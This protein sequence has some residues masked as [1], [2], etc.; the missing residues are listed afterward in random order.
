MAIAGVS[1]N[2]LSSD[3]NHQMGPRLSSAPNLQKLPQEHQDR[4]SS[5]DLAE[6]AGPEPV[7]YRVAGAPAA[8][9]I[10]APHG[11]RGALCHSNSDSSR[12]RPVTLPHPTA[13]KHSHHVTLPH[14]MAEKHSRPVNRRNHA[15]N[16]NWSRFEDQTDADHHHYAAHP[17]PRVTLPRQKAGSCCC[18]GYPNPTNELNLP[19]ERASTTNSQTTCCH[20]FQSVR[21]DLMV[22]RMA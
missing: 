11:C 22:F 18:R 2:S 1:E 19:R 7:E 4:V 12:Y 9:L 6:V 5:D 14:Q 13:E 10:H 17:N 8:E 15:V 16:R 3:G 20:H 21:L